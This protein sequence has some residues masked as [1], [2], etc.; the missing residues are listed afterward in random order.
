MKLSEN[1]SLVLSTSTKKDGNMSLFK[2]DAKNVVKNREKFLERLGLNTSEIVVLK[3]VHK[4]NVHIATEKDLGKG[5]IDKTTA[6]LKDAL[7]T[8]AKEVYLFVLTADCL[9]IAVYD[10]VNQAIGLIHASKYNIDSIIAKTI[11]KMTH[12]FK[13]RPKD[14]VFEIGPSIGPCHYNKDLWL[15]AQKQIEALG[16][17]KKNMYNEKI[18]TYSENYYSH[19]EFTE[20]G[21]NED[22][23]VA[24]VFGMK[25]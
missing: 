12:E 25:G 2:G 4:S 14:L 23:R 5:A 24:T 20:K 7:I 17:E 11:K 1:K 19:R 13:T 22:N 15:K 16:V 21:L 18:C 8:N 10:P 9:P 6:I 3:L